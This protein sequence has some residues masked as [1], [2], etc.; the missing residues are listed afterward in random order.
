MKWSQRLALI[1]APLALTVAG[2]LPGTAQASQCDTVVFTVQPTTTQ[3]GTVMTPAVTVQVEQPGGAVD[4]DYN[5]PVTVSYAANQAGAPA[6]AGA[7][8]KAV[9]GTATFRD[10]KFSAV[11]FGFTLQASIPGAASAASVPFDIVSQLV[12]CAAGKSCQSGTVS[13]SGTSASVTAAATAS[14]GVL[15]ATGGGFPLLSCTSYGGVVSVSAADRA[16]VITVTLDKALVSQAKAQ[17]VSKFGI[18]WGAPA[19]FATVSGQSAAFNPANGE[20]EG[21]LPDCKANGPSPCVAHRSNPCYGPE[22]ITV[23]APLGDPHIT[24]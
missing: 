7:T 15:T 5:G 18:C 4:R 10:L 21:L 8:V 11:G 9:K 24:F 22:V 20:Y 23:D 16:K 6:P 2:L 1:A 19:P 14:G 12:H 17:G 3:A 13:S